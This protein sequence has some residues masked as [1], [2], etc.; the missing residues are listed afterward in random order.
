MKIRMSEALR[1]I[2]I[3]KPDHFFKIKIGSVFSVISTSVPPPGSGR[4]SSEL[5]TSWVSTLSVVCRAGLLTPLM[6]RLLATS[7]P[8]SRRR[9]AAAWVEHVTR[10]ARHSEKLVNE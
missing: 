1:F 2:S 10:A 9:V 7:G 8:E 3:V 5:V 6:E 4:L